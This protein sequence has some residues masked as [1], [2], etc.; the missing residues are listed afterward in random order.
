[1]EKQAGGSVDGGAEIRCKHL[2][3]VSPRLISARVKVKLFNGKF[4][5]R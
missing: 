2:R 4:Y 3:Q 5:G 1:M